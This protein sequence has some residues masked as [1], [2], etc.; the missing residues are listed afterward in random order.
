MFFANVRVARN[1]QPHSPETTVPG[2][3]MVDDSSRLT[4]RR[5]ILVLDERPHVRH[6]VGQ[7][8]QKHGYE[9]IE[10]GSVS[11][12][13]SVSGKTEITAVLL[14]FSEGPREG[15]ARLTD[16]RT[17]PRFASTPAAIMTKDALPEPDQARVTNL[18]AF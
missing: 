6:V 16:L 4:A 18:R 7:F 17:N 5:S 8:L 10:A 1:V 15:V 9:P 12:A 14:D 2:S 11:E 3:S 13:V